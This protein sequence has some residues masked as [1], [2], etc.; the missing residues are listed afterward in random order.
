[1]TFSELTA[2]LQTRLSAS[3]SSTFYTQTLLKSWLNIAYR[4]SAGLYNWPFSEKA[5]K[6][7][8]IAQSEFKYDIYDYPDN[9][10]PFKTDSI[11]RLT[12]DDKKYDKKI[13]QDFLDF[14]DNNPD[15][16]DK[17]YSDWGRQ[18]F[19]FPKLSAGLNISIWGQIVPTKLTGDTDTTIFSGDPEAE[20]AI[21]KKALSIALAKGKKKQEAMIEE[22]EATDILKIV[23]SKIAKRQAQYQSKDRPFFDIPNFYKGRGSGQNTGKFSI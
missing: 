4:W 16:T 17:I 7:T 19:I 2:E 22:K 12:V 5:K 13:Y 3:S 15:S 21:I 11:S 23:W 6:T 14:I 10:T 20:E 1:M 8:S 9:T 18:Y